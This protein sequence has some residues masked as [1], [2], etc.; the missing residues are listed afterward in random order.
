MSNL[1]GV[2]SIKRV[3][4]FLFLLFRNSV[5][6]LCESIVLGVRRLGCSLR[7]GLYCCEILSY[8]L[9][10]LDYSFFG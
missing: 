7:F 6:C 2:Y 9:S 4:E 1:G 5:V 3:L 8:C 10:F